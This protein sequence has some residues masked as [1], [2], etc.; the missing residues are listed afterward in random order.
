LSLDVE[1]DV[2]K[3]LTIEQQQMFILWRVITYQC[4]LKL[5]RKISGTA[6]YIYECMENTILPVSR[7]RTE[8]AVNHC[9]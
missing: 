1:L 5:N 6:D 2:G 7:A 4:V 8:M 9:A 3:L